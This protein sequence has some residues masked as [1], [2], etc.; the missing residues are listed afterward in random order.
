MTLFS[1]R[2]AIASLAM[3]SLAPTVLQAQPRPASVVV[4]EARM[5]TVER[6]RE[7]VGELRAVRR[8]LL[9]A[10]DEGIVVEFMLEEGDRVEAGDVIARLRDTRAEFELRRAQADLSARRAAL[11]ERVADL[12]RARRDLTRIDEV[13]HLRGSATQSELEDRRTAV[14]TGEARVEHA[15]AEIESAEATLNLAK[16]RLERRTVSAPFSGT[17]VSRRTEIGQWVRQGD[18]LVELVALE[19]IEA[20]LQIPETLV[21]RLGRPAESVHIRIPATGETRSAPITAI[22]PDVD[23]RSRLIPVRL[24]LEN[25]DM[26]LRPGMSALG[27]IATGSHEPALTIH[28]DAVLRDDAGEFVYFDGGGIAAVARI[29]SLFPVGERIAIRSGTLQAGM[30]VVVEGNERLFPTQPLDI[31]STR[32]APPVAAVVGSPPG[33]G[34]TPAQTDEGQGR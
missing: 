6:Y 17:I 9:A 25:K 29:Q 12:E 4:D 1:R 13:L 23:P 20:R 5:E 18:P 10:E 27:L 26:R 31:R 14:N 22:L 2:I 16:D 32:G 30:A 15:A 33:G 8:A 21:E 3:A 24:R 28:K 7:V 34:R 19:E 11:A